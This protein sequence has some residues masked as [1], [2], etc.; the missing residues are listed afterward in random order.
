MQL[1]IH[2]CPERRWYVDEFLV[3][4]MRR[5][6]IEPEVWLDAKRKG[7]LSACMEA[8][9]ACDGDGGT[10]HLQDDVLPARDFAERVK[11]LADGDAVLCGFVNELGGPDCNLRGWVYM[12]DM[13]YSFPCTYIPNAIA[14]ECAEWW[15]S[16][17]WR[18]EVQ[19][20][21]ISAAEDGR[22]DDFLF[23]EF[24]EIHHGGE[25][26]LNLT[27]CLVEHVD[28]LI[29]GSTVSPFR[30]YYARAVYWEDEEL[31]KNLE[32]RIK[33]RNALRS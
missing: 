3:P 25:M 15:F 27:P 19:A 26:A 20:L 14:R 11:D 21:A 18:S 22:G 17:A 12:P 31:V 30:G 7:N 9:A 16:G 23:R 10:W 29:G 8:F 4:E 13:W 28:W 2:A 5:Q 6:G 32:Q 24:M 33:A 1:M